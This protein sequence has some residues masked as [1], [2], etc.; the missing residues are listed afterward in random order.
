MTQYVVF[1]Y[2]S[3]KGIKLTGRERCDYSMYLKLPRLLENWLTDNDQSI[4]EVSV[5][6][7]SNL[8]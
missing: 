8:L 1:C 7:K 5:E 6:K 3:T 2:S 4:L